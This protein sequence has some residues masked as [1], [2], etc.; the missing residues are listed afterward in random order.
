MSTT[1]AALSTTTSRSHPVRRTTLAYGAVAAV[2][3]TGLAAAAHGA[4]VSLEIDGQMIPFAG[5]AQMVLLGAFLGGL[6]AAAL[7]RYS[8]DAY[9]WFVRT[10]VA[11]T[12]LSCVPSVALPHDA[13]TKIVLVTTHVVAALIIVPALA[14]QTR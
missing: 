8:S 12:A 5:F 1:A 9:R 11:L 7:N 2:A 3:T 4:G 10:A 14:R 6:L 13:A